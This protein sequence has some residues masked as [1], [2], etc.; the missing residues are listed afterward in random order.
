MSGVGG[1]VG[2]SALAAGM[3]V[4]S[5]RH[6]A[7]GVGA[8]AAPVAAPSAMGPVR[9]DRCRCRLLMTLRI[10]ANKKTPMV[11]MTAIGQLDVQETC[12]CDHH[13]ERHQFTG[14][15]SPNA[16]CCIALLCL[17]LVYY[18]AATLC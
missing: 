1:D 17:A 6:G 18:T 8:G 14:P 9:G 4:A 5:E 7:A 10:P 15:L 3:G 2:S 11:I 16:L 13:W 12:K